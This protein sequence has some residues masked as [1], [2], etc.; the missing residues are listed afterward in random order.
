MRR[1]RDGVSRLHDHLQGSSYLEEIIK[2]PREAEGLI[3]TGKGVE[4]AM[5]SHL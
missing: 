5:R 3:A 4:V 1:W 2:K